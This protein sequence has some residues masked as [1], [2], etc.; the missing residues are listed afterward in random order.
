MARQTF[1]RRHEIDQD[2]TAILDPDA[3]W[4]TPW[5]EP[6]HGSCDKC[7]GAETT[8]YACLSC[9]E[10]V[11]LGDCP[12]CQGRVHFTDICPACEGSG[13][14]DHTT[15]RGVSAFPSMKGLY[16]YLVERNA[17]LEGCVVLEFVAEPSDERDLDADAGAVLVHPISVLARHPVDDRYVE[18][19]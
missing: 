6:D 13:V 18:R 7:D 8:P 10:D 17:D 16:R 11:A 5:G 9:I 14:I 3:Q 19:L 12:A 2:S 4:S 1:F 15:R